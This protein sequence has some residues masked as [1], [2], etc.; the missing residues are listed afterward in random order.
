MGKG[1][2][3]RAMRALLPTGRAWDITQPTGLRKIFEAIAPLPEDI[4]REFERVYFDY[5]PDTTRALDKW[6]EVFHVIFASALFSDDERRT[7]LKIMWLLRY[8]NTTGEF[9]RSVLDVLIPGVQV[10]DNVPVANAIG[11]VFAYK[12]VNGNKYMCCG[13]RRAVCNFHVGD[14]SWLP[15]ILRNDSQQP[16]D[17]PFDARY[18]SM[19]F[20][21]SGDVMR[22]GDGKFIAF[23]RKKV[24]E[25]WQQFI[26]F[27]VLALKP[28]QSTAIMFIKYVPNDADTSDVT[29]LGDMWNLGGTYEQIR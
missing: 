15:A 22:D 29:D 6:E 9:M 16:Y 26:E 27:I 18:W 11:L 25:K 23:A 8:G 1:L 3:F 5:F 19:C 17:I 13:N 14:R 7:V 28:V 20:F 24:H 4:R 2:F 12:S 10:T 21:I